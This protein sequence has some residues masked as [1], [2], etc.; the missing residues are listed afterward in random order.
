MGFGSKARDSVRISDMNSIVKVLELSYLKNNY[1]PA[2]GS[3][4]EVTYSG[5]TLWTQ[6]YFNDAV[7]IETQRISE[8]PI[9]PLV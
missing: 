6:G 4:F 9:E 1:Y 2:T 8:V 7:R 5:S 3:G